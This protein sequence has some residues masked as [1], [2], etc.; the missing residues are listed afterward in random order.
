MRYGDP[1]GRIPTG[2]IPAGKATGQY[3]TIMRVRVGGLNKT[4]TKRINY[5]NLNRLLYQI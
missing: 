4:I 1:T 3:T 2:I 5:S